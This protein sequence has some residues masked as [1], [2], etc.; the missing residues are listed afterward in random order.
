MI[1]GLKPV[2]FQSNDGF[3]TYPPKNIFTKSVPSTLQPNLLGLEKW[4]ANDGVW[5][6]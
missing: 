4:R 5:Q 1:E 3:P 2:H 6:G